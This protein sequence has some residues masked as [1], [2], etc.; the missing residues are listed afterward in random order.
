MSA[1][2]LH[3]A[4]FIDK[5][6]TLVHNV[7]YNVDPALL[8]FQPGAL[9]A[10][11]ALAD[12]GFQLVL[13]TNQSGLARGYFSEDDFARLGRALRERLRDQAGV[14]LLDLLHC[15]HA[16][17]ALGEPVCECRKP[18]PGLLHRAAVRHGLDLARSWMVGDTLDDVEA[19]HRSGCRGVLYDSGGETLWRD[20][21]LRRPY[22]REIHWDGVVQTILAAHQTLGA[23][24]APGPLIAV[25]SGGEPSPL[26]R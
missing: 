6:G 2:P 3:P 17:N 1:R 4:V 12:A 16:P 24:A 9:R 7:P 10:V 8:R 22:A 5:D 19:G 18:M 15:P 13:I 25:P 14:E 26:S 11:R 21:A 20:G 23:E